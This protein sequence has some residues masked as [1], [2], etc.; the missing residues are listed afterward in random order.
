MSRL[1]EAVAGAHID[2]SR[3]LVEESYTGADGETVYRFRR[4]D[5]V[6]C[7]TSGGVAAP[8]PG[9]TEG[10]VL[11]GAGRFD[12]LGLSGNAGAIECPGGQ[13]DWIKR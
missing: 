4:G 8:M 1:R 3:T 9:R 13:H 12:T 5:K 10:A 11:A 6:Y 2:R 7:R